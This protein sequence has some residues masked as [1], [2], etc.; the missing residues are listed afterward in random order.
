MRHSD[1]VLRGALSCCANCFKRLAKRNLNISS[2]VFEIYRFGHK[3]KYSEFTLGKNNQRVPKHSILRCSN[4]HLRLSKGRQKEKRTN[5]IYKRKNSCRSVYQVDLYFDRDRTLDF[6]VP[7]R[8]ENTKIKKRHKH[9][10]SSSLFSVL[11]CFQRKHG[12]VPMCVVFLI[13]W[14]TPRS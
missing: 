10:N 12:S 4:Y 13:C 5:F 3:E 1:Q 11:I 8:P 14:K 9:W 2:A 6:S 7:F